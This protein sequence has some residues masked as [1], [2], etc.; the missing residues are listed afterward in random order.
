MGSSLMGP[1]CWSGISDFQG[2]VH[3]DFTGRTKSYYLP[4]YEELRKA[5]GKRPYALVAMNDDIVVYVSY[6]KSDTI[7][8]DY[9]QFSTP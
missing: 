8:L 1:S 7:S 5:N 6:P 2:Q 4:L 9:E 3:Y